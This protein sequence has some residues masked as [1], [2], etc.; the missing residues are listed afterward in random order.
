MAT[1]SEAE[2]PTGEEEEEPA[3]KKITRLVRMLSVVG[4]LVA[5][6]SAG[7]M[8]SLYYIFLW[9][10]Y[11]AE[12]PGALPL[13]AER[14]PLPAGLGRAAHWLGE[15]PPW[16]GGVGDC[17]SGPNVVGSGWGDSVGSLQGE[18]V[19]A[20]VGPSLVHSL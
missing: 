2:K 18:G 6:S 17:S 12:T 14:P 20:M 13:V 10:P 8:V 5:V 11:G 15:S 9:D 4:Y 16:S 19:T 3:P 7:V 1:K